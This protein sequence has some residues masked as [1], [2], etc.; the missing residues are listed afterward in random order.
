MSSSRAKRCFTP[1]R[2]PAPSSPTVAA[3]ITG[4]CVRTRAPSIVSASAS[5]AASPRELSTIPGPVKLCA[6]ARHAD[7]GAFGEHRVEVCAD[8]HGCLTRGAGSRRDHVADGVGADVVQAERLEPLRHL[9]AA[10]V[11]RA[12][13]GGDLGKRDL[14]VDDPFVVGGE[15]CA[16]GREACEKVGRRGGRDHVAGTHAL[17]MAGPDPLAQDAEGQASDGANG[18]AR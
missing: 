11:L 14:R 17:S 18:L 3:K 6:L 1:R 16:G 12:G 5:I 15:P 4:R 9:G 13:G 2:S 10:R 7:G 8:Q